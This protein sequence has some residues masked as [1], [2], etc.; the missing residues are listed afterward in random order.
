MTNP[1]NVWCAFVAYK[2]KSIKDTPLTVKQVESRRT[3]KHTD[4]FI[5]HKAKKNEIQLNINSNWLQNN[6][7][8]L[9]LK[10]KKPSRWTNCMGGSNSEQT[11]Q[12][13]IVRWI[14]RHSTFVNKV[15]RQHFE[16]NEGKYN[17]NEGKIDFQPC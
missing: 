14:A 5:W 16:Q 3:I 2:K 8:N 17:W 11:K 7:K 4:V 15:C 13:P 9:Q 6:C 10:I 12:D 1:I